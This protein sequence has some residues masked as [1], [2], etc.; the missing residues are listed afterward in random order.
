MRTISRRHV[1]TT[2]ATV[3]M[4]LMFAQLPNTSAPAVTYCAGAAAYPPDLP[5]C[6]DPVVE[7][8]RNAQAAADAL[9]AAQAAAAKKQ[10]DDAA[11]AAAAAALKA[12]Q[13]KAE[14]D[15]I[16]ASVAAA[17][18]QEQFAAAAAAAAETARKAQIA[19]EQAAAEAAAALQAQ[20]DKENEIA[21][22]KAKAE[23]AAAKYDAPKGLAYRLNQRGRDD[24]GILVVS[25]GH[26]ES[27]RAF[28][29]DA[30]KA[31]PVEKEEMSRP[32]NP[33]AFL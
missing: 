7:A 1:V 9:A 32:T 25:K 30:A 6:L 24:R 18:T 16:A 2:V 5:D 13:D 31:G 4:S 21:A 17:R 15:A 8:A 11:A 23:A 27:V 10:A 20:R 33:Y 19:K 3:V 28:A 26:V 14:Q 29:I 22:A 12:A